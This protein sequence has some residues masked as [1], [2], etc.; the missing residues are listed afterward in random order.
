MCGCVWY[1]CKCVLEELG[2]KSSKEE[3]KGGVVCE[4]RKRERECVLEELRRVSSG[5]ECIK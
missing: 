2:G 5:E 3:N 4:R 1:V